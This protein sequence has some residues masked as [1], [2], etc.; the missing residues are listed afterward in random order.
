[1]AEFQTWER[2]VL[3]HG[4]IEA[5][6][7]GP[8]L[9]ESFGT[10]LSDLANAAAG[11]VSAV[12]KSDELR[13][14]K[15]WE[16]DQ[17]KAAAIVNQL[18]LQIA[19][20]LP[21]LKAQAAPGLTDYPDK[22]NE[23]ITRATEAALKENSDPRFQ[24]YVRGY[25]DN[26]RVSA[27]TTGIQERTA[28]TL[29]RD[30]DALQSLLDGQSKLVIQDFANYD[31]A[32]GL[33]DETIAA[34][35]HLGA[36]RKS[37]F[38]S[39]AKHA[40]A[41]AG[42]DALIE[43]D[44]DAADRVL[45]SGKLEGVLS[46]EDE[47]IY[48]DTIKSK[49]VLRE[50]EARLVQQQQQEKL[51]ADGKVAR[52]RALNAARE[53]GQYDLADVA[54]IKRAFPDQFPEIHDELVHERT[55]GHDNFVI[56]SQT[57]A[58]DQELQDKIEAQWA[59]NPHDA[60]LTEQLENVK[61]Q[62]R[63]KQAALRNNPEAYV[64]KWVPDVQKGW[65][66]LAKHPDDVDRLRKTMELSRQAQLARGVDEKS[67]RVLPETMGDLYLKAASGPD[68]AAAIPQINEALGDDRK[69]LLEQASRKAGPLVNVALMLE[70]EQ[71]R[72]RG[73]LL[74]IN[75]SGGITALEATLPKKYSPQSVLRRVRSALDD[76]AP[77]F[78][79]QPGGAQVLERIRTSVYALTLN[80]IETQ[81]ME[82]TEAAERATREVATDHYAVR[83][84]NGH[85]YRIPRSYDASI[86]P[87]M[88]HKYT[89]DLIDYGKVDKPAHL[90]SLPA[91]LVK[92]A[93]V[94]N[95]YWTTRG[96][97][98]G[99]YLRAPTG[100]PVTIEG[101]SITVLWPELLQSGRIQGRPEPSS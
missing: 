27:A 20:Q 13:A 69:E 79:E 68:G 96:D 88:L 9:A 14:D 7:A 58:Q 38:I 19:E 26:F 60:A 15:Q 3:P 55:I 61:E 35:R 45:A 78:A 11:A 87:E 21:E 32:A 94:N 93:L 86:I 98:Q 2:G 37:E 95:G 33:M 63:L 70:P 41:K 39:I 53:T 100:A 36:D 82:P 12:Q 57:E 5:A 4:G 17:P 50:S 83:A 30:G 42:L 52:D 23:A 1:M 10:G 99:L 46:T 25:M 24:R 48:R 28:A 80:Y 34:N 72:V 73:Q 65:E 18:Q 51:Q 8:S 43:R 16:I 59:A 64:R 74:Q 85:S 54:V 67:V 62:R 56:P 49:R 97:E 90:Q 89:T 101:K 66:E 47:Q 76:L 22:I 31:A 91:E 29:K 44:H 81:H 40:L 75:G 77:S 71:D 84:Y 92:S 6:Q